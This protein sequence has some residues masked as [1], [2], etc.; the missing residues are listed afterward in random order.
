M[1]SPEDPFTGIDLD[2]CRNPETGSVEPWAQEI[3][4]EL[5][6]YTEVSPSGT[7]LHVI[8]Q[9]KLPAGR[10][11]KGRIEMYDRA[12]FFCV[13]G[14]H[15]EG[16]PLTIGDR[17]EQV[18]ALHAE[19]FGTSGNETTSS[20]AADAFV[21][22][23]VEPDDHGLIDKARKAKNGDRFAQLFDAGDFSAYDSQSEA[24]LALCS[25]L[26]FWTHGDAPRIDRLFRRSALYRPKWDRPHFGDGR[27]YGAVTIERAFG[28]SNG[29]CDACGAPAPSVEFGTEPLPDEDVPPPSGDDDDPGSIE[30]RCTDIANGHRLAEQYGENLRW[31]RAFN[32][33]LVWT[34]QR[35]RTDNTFQAERWAKEVARRI[36]FE[37]GNARSLDEQ[38]ALSK[39]AKQSSMA[40]GQAAMLLMARSEPGIAVEPEA[41]DRNPWLLSCGN[42][43][44]DLRTGNL[45]DSRRED[46]ITKGIDIAYDPT[47]QC[48]RWMQ[49]ASEVMPNNETADWLQRAVGYSLTGDTTDRSFFLLHGLGSNGKTVFI[50]TV[51]TLLGEYAQRTPAEALMVQY[52]PSGNA[53]TPEIARLKGA[54]FVSATEL[55]DGQRF[56]EAFI[57][58]VTGGDT[59]TGCH[60]YA[61]PFDFKPTH[62]L[63]IGTNHLPQ[64]G[65][66]GAFWNR[67]RLIPFTVT[68]PPDQ[69]DPDLQETLRGELPGILAWAVRG[70]VLYQEKGLGP[71]PEVRKATAAY[72]EEQDLVANFLAE[73]TEKEP[74][75]GAVLAE[76][77]RVGAAQ[78]Y[79]AFTAWC[80]AN[81]ERHPLSVKDFKKRLENKGLEQRAGQRPNR[82]SLFWQGIRLVQEDPSWS[83][84][85]EVS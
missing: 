34:G 68:I 20:A 74:P 67:V 5:D 12:R 33:W 17:Q 27:T 47:A 71:P 58:A 57:K 7:G 37:A 76:E 19:V 59:L 28:G 49:F 40:K 64:A 62:K 6:S 43:T 38:Q 82:G 26:A 50:E 8:V 29:G 25:H 13:T 2:R 73:R 51:M 81:G 1:F 77:Y 41:L 24:D 84:T 80:Q 35:W 45:M 60:K 79:D 65:D 75:S 32:S 78:L 15:L 4:T 69:I 48:L 52:K 39:W 11:R 21:R 66:C 44:L 56:S 42:G 10:R 55:E 31:Y 63:W 53:P 83:P 30:L 22:G 3:I 14:D 54:R 23:G 18:N 9:G 70:A 16:T 72:R 61:K 46:L 36:H 85:E